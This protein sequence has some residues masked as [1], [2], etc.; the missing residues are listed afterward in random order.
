MQKLSNSIKK[1][2]L[3]IG[4]EDQMNRIEDPDTS[5]HRNAYLIFDKVTQN[6]K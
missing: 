4:H 5:P 2:N 1:P 6:M 3:R